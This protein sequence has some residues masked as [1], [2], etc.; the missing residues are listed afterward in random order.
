MEDALFEVVSEFVDNRTGRRVLP[1]EPIPV[2]LP[3]ETIERLRRAGCLAPL[4]DGGMAGLNLPQGAAAEGGGATAS[5]FPHGTA[6]G[7]AQVAG[8]AGGNRGKRAKPA[9]L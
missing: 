9:G 1:G 4:P 6:S 2:G 3:P 5:R 7:T 8:R